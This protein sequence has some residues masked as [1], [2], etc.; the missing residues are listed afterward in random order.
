MTIKTI[1]TQHKDHGTDTIRKDA[2]RIQPSKNAFSWFIIRD[3]VR[4]RQPKLYPSTVEGELRRS[5]NIRLANNELWWHNRGHYEFVTRCG[6]PVIAD[7]QC[8]ARKRNLLLLYV[9]P[10]SDSR[11]EVSSPCNWAN[12]LVSTESVQWIS[13]Q[14]ETFITI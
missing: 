1:T 8:A 14:P 2:E 11:G 5:H 4:V 12:R 6:K 13:S 10:R 9:M 3:Y 7:V